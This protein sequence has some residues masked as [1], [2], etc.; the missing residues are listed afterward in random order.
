MLLMRSSAVRPRAG[1]GL[2]TGLTDRS[3]I[4]PRTAKGAPVGT[5]V[6]TAFEQTQ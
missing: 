3:H 2:P 4:D 1:E 6:G 5:L